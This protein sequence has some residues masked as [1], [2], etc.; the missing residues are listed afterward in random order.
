MTPILLIEIGLGSSFGKLNYKQSRHL[1]TIQTKY[2]LLTNG[3]K[4]NSLG[5]LINK[6]VLDNC[7]FDYMVTIEGTFLQQST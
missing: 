5:K 2:K 6:K 3:I 1:S 7:L 4:E